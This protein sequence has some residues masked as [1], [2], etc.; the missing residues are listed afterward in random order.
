MFQKTY[1]HNKQKYRAV[2]YNEQAA[3]RCVGCAADAPFNA[4]L[5]HQLP[6]C[7]SLEWPF[8]IIWIKVRPRNKIGE[9]NATKNMHP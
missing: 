8:D 2:P 5:C 9:Q 1:T 3:K 4:A 7:T 6:G